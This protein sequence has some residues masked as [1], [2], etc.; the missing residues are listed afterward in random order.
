MLVDEVELD[1]WEQSRS[2]KHNVFEIVFVNQ[3]T[4]THVINEVRIPYKKGNIFLL[5]PE[6]RHHFE[7]DDR[8]RFTFARFTELLFSDKST[9]PDRT[10]WLKKI[11]HILH[12]PNLMPGDAIAD[13][14]DRKTI[15]LAKEVM[16]REYKDQKEFFLIILSNNISTILSIIA[17]NII[18]RYKISETTPTV[19]I[20]KADEILSYIRVNVYDNELMKIE[21]LA[22]HFHMSPHYINTFFKKETGENI[23]Q[24][25]LNYKLLITEF[26][27]KHTSNSISEIAHHVGF[28]D[29]SHLSKAF[30]KKHQM[31]PREYREKFASKDLVR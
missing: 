20:N 18:Q 26:R 29:E 22:E 15:W 21:N 24:Y 6:D 31:T 30:R 17:R 2:H 1:R 16:V 10:D 4:G 12:H 9:L 8:T 28:N 13:D 25:I 19:Y 11:E 23:R 7:I 3:G 27:L 14:E 5:A